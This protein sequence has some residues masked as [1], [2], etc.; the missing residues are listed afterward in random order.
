[1]KRQCFW[2]Q[3]LEPESEGS[4]R[5]RVCVVTENEPKYQPTGGGGVSPWYWDRETCREMNRRRFGL[6]PKDVDRIVLSSMFCNA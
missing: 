5:F 3:E 6:E 1:M 4:D 2:L